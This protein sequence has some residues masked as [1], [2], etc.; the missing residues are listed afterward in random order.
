MF[1]DKW[2]EP[3]LATNLN[4]CLSS[5]ILNTKADDVVITLIKDGHIIM[6]KELKNIIKDKIRL[7]K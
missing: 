4:E 3:G 5:M 7:L 2:L 6:K 1:I